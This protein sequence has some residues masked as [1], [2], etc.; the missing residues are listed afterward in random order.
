MRAVRSTTSAR[1]T[2]DAAGCAGVGDDS[3]SNRKLN[4]A[5]SSQRCTRAPV[6]GTNSVTTYSRAGCGAA[7]A[8]TPAGLDGAPVSS[9]RKKRARVSGTAYV[10]TLLGRYCC[11]PG[12]VRIVRRREPSSPA[13]TRPNGTPLPRDASDSA[14]TVIGSANASW[15][16]AGAPPSGGRTVSA[17]L[18]SSSSSAAPSTAPACVVTVGRSAATSRS[19]A[20]VRIREHRV[21]AV[22]RR[23]RRRVP[24]AREVPDRPVVGRRMRQHH[25]DAPRALHDRVAPH[26][27]LHR[28][29]RL[30]PRPAGEAPARRGEEVHLEA[31][32]VGLRRGVAHG[33]EP[34]RRAEH[35]LVLDR[36]PTPG[37]DVGELEAADA[38][39]LHPLQVLRDPFLGDVAR[40]P[41]PPGA[42]PRA[43]RR[44]AEADLERIGGALRRG[45]RAQGVAS[46]ARREQ[47]AGRA[48]HAVGSKTDRIAVVTVATAS[49]GIPFGARLVAWVRLVAGLGCA[50][51]VSLPRPEKTVPR[52]LFFPRR[53]LVAARLHHRRSAGRT[54]ARHC[55]RRHHGRHR[56]RRRRRTASARADGRRTRS[57]NRSC[58]RAS[59]RVAVPTHARVIDG[60]GKFLVPGLWDMHVHLFRNRMDAAGE[61]TDDS[62]VFFPALV[63]NGV[64]GVRDMSTDLADHAQIRRWAIARTAGTLAAPR[65][66]GGSPLLSGQPPIQPNGL[67]LTTAAD[68][69]R[70]VDSLIDGGVGYLKVYS[71]LT[72]E[73]YFAI[74]AEARRRG[75]PFAGHVPASADAR[76]S[77]G[78][79]PAQ[80]RASPQ[81]ATKLL[82]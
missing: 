14:R 62:E 33:V 9:S 48:D 30:H 10:R 70:V 81:R 49:G 77:V 18:R 28:L 54:T 69:R 27:L 46:S 22:E 55:P 47:G 6:C 74:A 52:R 26:E 63:A 78:R 44:I 3:Y 59:A 24:A 60:H 21:V 41:V 23:I 53:A 56:H 25:R 12:R 51:A 35:D 16:H 19:S 36:L 32:P 15:I 64:T 68:A 45:R 7:C 38:D 66:I 13:S 43:R 42:R 61:N 58:R 75:V 11:A 73:V 29:R 34:L 1:G 2:T 31:E 82:G 37:G 5:F 39:A 57:P 8:I 20:G 80:L 67:V 76:R 17:V 40:R 71:G 4:P 79:R 50:H 65:I 72:R